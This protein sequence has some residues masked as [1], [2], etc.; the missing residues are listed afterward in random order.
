MSVEDNILIAEFDG[1]KQKHNDV[2]SYVRRKIGGEGYNIVR[3]DKLL[4]DKG[5]WNALVP[6]VKKIFESKSV[7]LDF[8]D[9]LCGAF[10]K[11]DYDGAYKVVVEYIKWYHQNK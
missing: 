4:Y 6:V 10:I 2:N 9:R 3:K 1:W 11:G 7:P 5:S 8:Y